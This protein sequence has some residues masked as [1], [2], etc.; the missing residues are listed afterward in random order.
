MGQ[1]D[2]QGMYLEL[3]ARFIAPWADETVRHAVQAHAPGLVR[4]PPTLASRQRTAGAL[5][6]RLAAATLGAAAAWSL[7]LYLAVR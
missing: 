2:A 1:A 6:T 5:L 4:P 3:V 7:A